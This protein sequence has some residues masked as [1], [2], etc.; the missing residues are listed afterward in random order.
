MS[1]ILQKD[2][3]KVKEICDSLGFQAG[4]SRPHFQLADVTHEWRRRYR[5]E[6]G[7]PGTELKEWRNLKTQDGLDSMAEEFLER[8]GEQLWPVAGGSLWYYPEHK[9]T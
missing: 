2:I 5:T 6:D 3:P 1:N 7:T 4:S 8:R 9:A